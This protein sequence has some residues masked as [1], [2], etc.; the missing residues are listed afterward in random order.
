MNILSIWFSLKFNITPVEIAKNSTELIQQISQSFSPKLIEIEKRI[1]ELSHTLL[2]SA[3]VEDFYEHI[4]DERLQN[5]FL[6]LNKLTLQ[7]YSNL[8]NEEFFSFSALSKTKL[9]KY[10]GKNKLAN[11]CIYLT[12][13]L[14]SLLAKLTTYPNKFNN[15]EI[16]APNLSNLQEAP[17]LVRSLLEEI[18]AGQLAFITL[19]DSKDSLYL[20]ARRRKFHSLL[21]EH[22]RLGMLSHIK[23]FSLLE[24]EFPSISLNIPEQ[25]VSAKEKQQ[26]LEQIQRPSS[27]DLEKSI[28]PIKIEDKYIDS[29]IKAVQENETI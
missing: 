11:E 14:F 19:I 25:L 9:E 10:L 2:E 23:L 15:D 22:V 4:Y 5:K 1:K 27:N 24:N 28:S 26:L 3:D 6:I 21:L 8:L 16:S 29:F 18:I 20:Q 7:E 13:T 17:P 12:E